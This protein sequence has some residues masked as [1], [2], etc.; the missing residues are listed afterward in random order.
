MSSTST[1]FIVP[2][3]PNR[4][5]YKRHSHTKE[6]HDEVTKGIFGPEIESHIA[7]A[8]KVSLQILRVLIVVR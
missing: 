6:T 8:L 3:A 7:V 4:Q 5:G 1:V 2:H